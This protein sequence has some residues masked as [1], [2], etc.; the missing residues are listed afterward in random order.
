MYV[1][2]YNN[3]TAPPSQI[4]FSVIAIYYVPTLWSMQNSTWIWH[5]A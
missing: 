1:I 5:A 3:I 2:Y 4:Y